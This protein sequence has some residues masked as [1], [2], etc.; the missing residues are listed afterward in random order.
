MIDSTGKSGR[1][2]QRD[3]ARATITDITTDTTDVSPALLIAGF[4]AYNAVITATTKTLR[5]LSPGV[6]R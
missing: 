3:R 5:R 4:D 1:D 6:E 2:E